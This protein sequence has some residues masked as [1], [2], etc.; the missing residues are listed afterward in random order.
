MPYGNVDI[1]DW[2]EEELIDLLS[3][4]RQHTEDIPTGK[5]KV[6]ARAYL[7]YYLLHQTITDLGLHF[8]IKIREKI[9]KAIT[10]EVKVGK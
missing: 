1:N 8:L 7:E 2:T 3:F 5:D 6:K 4:I 9:E 10:R